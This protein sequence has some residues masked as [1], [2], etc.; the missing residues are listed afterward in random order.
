MKLIMF[1]NFKKKKMF[2]LI[3]NIKIEVKNLIMFE[4]YF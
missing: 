2:K 4:C 1:E 3:Q